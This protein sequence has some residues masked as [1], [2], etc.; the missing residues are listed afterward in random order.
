MIAVPVLDRAGEVIGV[1]VL[2]TQAPRE[3]DDDVLNFLVHTAS[4]VAGA[5]ENAQ[6]YGEARRR[7]DALTT[8]TELSQSLAVGDPARGS[9][10]RGHARR[11]PA[12]GRRTRARSGASSRRPPSS[13]S[14]PP[15]LRTLPNR[16][17][18]EY[19]AALMLDLLRRRGTDHAAA[20]GGVEE[21]ERLLVAPLAAGEEQLGM[22]C[23]L[24][25]RPRLRRG[26]RGAAARG[27]QPDRPGAQEGGADRAADRGE[28]RQ[29]HV[30]GARR[31][32]ARAMA[33]AKAVEAR[34]DLARPHVFL[35]AERAP[36]ARSD[37]ALA[38]PR[39][40]VQ[41]R[42]RRALPQRLLRRP[43]RQ[44]AGAGAA[45]L[46]G[47]RRRG[48]AR[49][50]AARRWRASDGLV[51]GLSGRGPRRGGGRRRMREAA[52]AARIAARWPA[53]AARSPTTSSAP[54]ATSST[55]S[56][57]R[58]RTTATARRW[59]RCSTTTRRRHAQLVET[60][61]TLPGH[62]LAAWPRAPA[63]STSTPTPCASASTG[64]SRSPG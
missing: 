62:A 56:S 32:F 55:S 27:G 25:A 2:H 18:G 35:H 47:S 16:A 60:L 28:H 54:T 59:R 11:S 52:D 49:R 44:P 17:R 64:S 29:G 31:G 37:A 3:F 22:L 9:L 38:G 48:A 50:R 51:I 4:L 58:R 13:C 23:S 8:L 7:V 45:R 61:E 40:R 20:V 34:C 24:V 53:A 14:P 36:A 10:R 30:R 12:A 63:L 19:R 42:M 26:G 15:T 46:V 43:S 21:D 5:I 39:L 57:T 41:T 1:I 33:E 6:L